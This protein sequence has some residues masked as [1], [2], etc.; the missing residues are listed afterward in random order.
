MPDDVAA[1]AF[2]PLERSV[3]E[4]IRIILLARPGELLLH[5]QFGV[6]L[7]DYL[8]APNTIAT[9]RRIHDAIRAG[10]ERFEERIVLDRVEVSEVADAPERRRV[11]LAW[12]LKR[13]GAASTLGLEIRL[14]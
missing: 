11:D 6:G 13:T 4:Q 7:E 10:L 5:P 2:S 12:R 9:R 8:H 1:L 14:A 3:K